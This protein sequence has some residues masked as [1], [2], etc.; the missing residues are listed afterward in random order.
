LASGKPIVS[1]PLPEAKLLGNAVQIAKDGPG[2]ILA[3]ERALS[4]DTPELMALRQK[5][6]ASNTW[7]ITVENVLVKLREELH[8][9]QLAE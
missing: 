6:V 7:D 5:A 1:V 4:E 9:A 8:T 3:I 2:F